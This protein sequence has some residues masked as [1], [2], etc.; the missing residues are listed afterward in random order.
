VPEPHTR[1][2][3]VGEGVRIALFTSG[4][5]VVQGRNAR[6]WVLFTLEPRILR[7][8]ELGYEHVVHPRRFSP[9]AGVDESGKGD[10]FGPLVV[11][12]VF[13]QGDQAR[14]LQEAGIRDSKQISSQHALERM[15]RLIKKTV[16]ENQLTVT[17]GPA[18][19]NQLY[20]RMKNVNRI[21]AWGHARAVEN[22]LERAPACSRVVADQFAH[23]SVI[24]NA[25]MKKGRSITLEQQHRAESDPAVAAASIVARAAFVRY[26]KN[27]EKK[28]GLPFPPGASAQVTAA[29]VE[30]VKKRGPAELLQVAK[31][32]FRTTRKVLKEAGIP[33][34]QI[35]V[36]LAELLSATESSGASLSPD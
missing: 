34:E 7:R 3:A 5:C 33:P 26:L 10:Y 16:G 2:A 27:L 31:C 18:R 20:R 30:L 9:H 32:H 12:V 24:R 28:Y 14:I 4:K 13:L 6:D 29:A 21:L 19:Y 17:V 11:G 1:I 8:A 23:E 15:D 35:P 22:L 25:L 36:E